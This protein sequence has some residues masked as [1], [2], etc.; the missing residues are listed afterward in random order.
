MGHTSNFII[1]VELQLDFL[2]LPV[3]TMQPAANEKY[4]GGGGCYPK[5]AQRGSRSPFSFPT[6]NTGHCGHVLLS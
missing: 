6:L 5:R 1:A 2:L 4:A 3:V